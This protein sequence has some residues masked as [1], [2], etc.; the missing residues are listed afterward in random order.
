MRFECISCGS[1][2]IQTRSENVYF[3]YRK[4]NSEMVELRAEVPV[5]KCTECEFEYTDSDA[6]DAR[7]TAVC[8]YLGVLTPSEI[9][10][11]RKRYGMTRARFAEASTI[12]EASL[13]RWETGEII[14]NT[15]YDKYLRL[16]SISENLDRVLGRTAPQQAKA[17][18]HARPGTFRYIDRF[19]LATKRAD[20][21]AL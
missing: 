12:G 8:N 14:Q 3:P 20:E 19:E 18:S 11:L 5:R 1:S 13:A 9:I 2:E 17:T 6:D 15:A 4:S 21:F 10:E 16:L 7:H